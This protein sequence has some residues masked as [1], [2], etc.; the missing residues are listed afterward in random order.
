M[1][2]RVFVQFLALVLCAQI[3]TM[4]DDAWAK[5]ADVPKDLRLS[6]R[7][8]LSEMM[9]RLGSFR[10]TSFSGKHGNV[11]SAPT[12]AQREIFTAFGIDWR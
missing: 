1:R 3:R 10:Q 7:Y 9:L 2:G 8:P 4:L 6:R 5:R 11:V 12:K